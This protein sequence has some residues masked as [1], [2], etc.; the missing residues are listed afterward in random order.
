ME[1]RQKTALESGALIA[2]VAGI[3][4]ALNALSALG[5]FKRADMTE[6]EK[7]TLSKG[8]GHLLGSMKQDLVIDAYVTKGL[9]KLDAFVRDLRDLLQEYKNA[10]KGKFDY[11]LIEAKDEDTRKKAKD[12]GLVEQ[13]F[14]EASATDEKAAVTTGF[15][16]LVLRYGEQ[17]DVIK[18]LPPERTDGLEFWI[19]NKI[20]EIRDKGDDIHH[21]V[22]VLSGHDEIKPGDNNLAPAPNN[23][24]SMQAII[25]QNFPFYS[26][27][28]VDLKGG[29]SE[30]PDELDGLLITQPGKD[31]TEKE[32]RRIDQFVMKGKSLAVFASAV[33]LKANDATMSATLSTH[34]LDKLL[35]GYGI[36][37][38]QDVVLDRGRDVRV[39]MPTMGGL[40][41]PDFPAMLE[42]QDDPRFTDKEKLLDTGFPALFR[43][44]EVAMPLASSLT[45]SADKQPGTKMQVLMRSSPVAVH[46][47]GDSQDLKPFQKWGPKLKGAKQEQFAL[48]ASV[49]GT[50]KTAFA[51]S[52]GGD[53]MGVDA[54]ATSAKPARVFVLASSEFLANPFARA[55]NG[56][57]MGQYGQMMPSLGGDQQLQEIAGPYAQQYLTGSI[58]VFKNTLDWLSGDT[59]LLAVSAK[60]TSDPGLIYQD[61]PKLKI[62]AEMTDE[63][64]RRQDE[65]LKAA[66][67]SLQ[68][69]IDFALILGL[70][71]IFC[72]L[73]FV[74]WRMRLT[75]N[76]NVSL[77]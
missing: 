39:L 51:D 69:N 16:G 11:S 19:T 70:P 4:V 6:N 71:L 77:A 65:E 76:E 30:V 55:G 43:V 32:L 46:L 26:L 8:S 54:P 35:S 58:L 37:L 61:L 42:V 33:N 41:Q 18:F 29:E 66:R 10:G 40:A 13:P 75:A 24:I 1:K 17:Q 59:D 5:A 49:E 9:P 36:G 47:T 7:F 27:Q 31:L 38:Q 15:M 60:I 45:I 28:D 63:D 14:G 22:G 3:L 52:S 73:G 57:D 56:P 50:L 2:I 12:A 34:G 68:H 20:R 64:L 25:T 67:K 72:A 48:G 62:T 44:Q 23:K 74:R 21:K 53:K